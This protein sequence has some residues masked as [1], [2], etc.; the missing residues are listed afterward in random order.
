MP[1]NDH[2]SFPIP[3]KS[4]A[5][6]RFSADRASSRALL[7]NLNLAWLLCT[8]SAFQAWGA[9]GGLQTDFFHPLMGHTE[10]MCQLMEYRSPHLAF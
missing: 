8:V 3:A 10:M 4:V 7:L 2:V 6:R 1:I 5:F 9:L